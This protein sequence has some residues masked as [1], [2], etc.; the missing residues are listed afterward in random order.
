MARKFTLR[1]WFG[2]PRRLRFSRAGWIFVAVCLVLGVAAIATGNNLLFLLLGALLGMIAF[3]GWLSEA[4]L[5]GIRIAR[6]EPV[7]TVAGASAP[8]VY[9]L[10]N[11]KRRV[12]SYAV[13][14]G[15][16]GSDARTWTA[17]VPAGTS[18]VVRLDVRWERRGVYPLRGVTLGTSFPFGLFAKERDTPL[19]GEVV[20]WPRPA[21]AVS[22]SPPTPRRAPRGAGELAGAAGARGEYRSLRE[23]RAGDD[24]RD[25][26]WRST[27]RRGVAVVREYE[28]DATAA[29][30]L[31]LDLAEAPGAAAEAALE[32]AAA[33]VERAARRGSR[34][35]VC[36]PDALLAPGAGAAQRAQAMEVLARARFRP[37]AP[38]PAPPVPRSECVL[39]AAV[40]S[41]GGGWSEVVH[42]VAAA[43]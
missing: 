41:G 20:V 9:T 3:S 7:G 5:R 34:F 37:D 33:L 11:A 27:A 30:W 31:C 36:T 42:P 17:V 23:F 28:A 15:E 1:S 18:V 24:P 21:A 39:V 10:H 14:V 25:V 32:A 19:A 26:H 6:T 8:L 16:V 29:L 38:A 35:G 22:E 12:P 13:E 43:G 4:A 40:G 2:P